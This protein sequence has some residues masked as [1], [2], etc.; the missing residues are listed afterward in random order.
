MMDLRIEAFINLCE[1]R[2][3]TKTAEVLNLTQ[4]AITKQIQYLES[5]YNKKFFSYS[6]R[7]LILTEEGEVFL[8]YAKKIAAL[9]KQ[10]VQNLEEVKKK[11]V[12]LKFG[13]TL[14][15]GEFILG[16]IVTKYIK[17]KPDHKI[18]LTVDNTEA[19]LSMIGKGT[20]D[21]GF[22]EG[23]FNKE[24]FN[25]S[26]LLNEP[27][28]A[29]MSPSNKLKER[30]YIEIED[31]KAYPLI[32]REEGSG[33]RRVL[34]RALEEKNL[35]I[36]SFNKIYEVANM[37]VIK[38]MVKENIGIT[39]LYKACALKELQEGLLIEVP[40]KDFSLTREFN[41]ITNKDTLH[42]SKA[43]EFY[44]FAKSKLYDNEN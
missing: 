17:E 36:R 24:D 16:D 12:Y 41:F 9:E 8:E 44:N 27:F 39:F 37:N 29:V 23:L 34:E 10:M 22:V 33:T 15:I 6:N 1:T 18:S 20:L 13:A 32:L 31:L 7:K 5:F 11:E 25:S 3:Y 30:K 40:I 26:I 42:Y 19:I 35:S 2:S 21:F 14:T 43:M 28:I 4:P 38:Q